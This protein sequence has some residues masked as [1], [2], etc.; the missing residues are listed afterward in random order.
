M[1]DYTV[2]KLDD[3]TDALAGEY[4]GAMRF[5]TEPEPARGVAQE[6]VPGVRRIVD[7]NLPDRGQRADGR[8]DQDGAP[9]VRSGATRSSSR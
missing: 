8:R 4:P 5:L 6:V 2:R 1:T 7:G 9:C 3:A